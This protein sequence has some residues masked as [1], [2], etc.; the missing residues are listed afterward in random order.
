LEPSPEDVLA[1]MVGI[2]QPFVPQQVANLPKPSLSLVRA[3]IRSAGVGN[4]V[5]MSTNG[6]I[7]TVEHHA[8][9]VQAVARFSLWGADP[10]AVDD[11]VTGLH[12]SVFAKRN[13]LQSNGFL[14][15]TFDSTAPAEEVTGLGAW[16][17]SADYD[18]LY[19]FA[20][21]DTG[22]ASSLMVSVPV[23]ESAPDQ[24]WTVRG[25]VT[26]WDNHQAPLL[27]VR[28]PTTIV[29]IA[30][31]AFFPD[32]SQEPT[33]VVRIAR[34]FDGAPAPVNSGTLAAFIAQTTASSPARNV[35]VE[36]PTLSAL[37]ANFTPDGSPFDLGD[38]NNDGIPDRYVP[39]RLDL[40]SP[41][42]LPTIADRL[43]FSYQHPPF[44]RVAVVYIR[45]SRQG[46]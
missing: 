9:R 33:G 28:G 39:T 30:A 13:D 32:V 21:A 27:S 18:V 20:Y 44:D 2:L 29:T 1:A 24:R 41:I 6:S 3:E 43:E 14:R 19:E 45:A 4:Y 5:G 34:M 15:L 37:L 23:D 26:R 31:L 46:G 40:P 12:A 11:A 42:V 17:R 7:A 16:R 8:I 22:D 10:F 38:W 36:L 35:Y 25:D